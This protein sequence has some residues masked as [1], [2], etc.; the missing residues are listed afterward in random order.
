MKAPHAI[1]L[2]ERHQ[3]P[4]AAYGDVERDQS[5]EHLFYLED[6]A[7]AMAPLPTTYDVLAIQPYYFS[8]FGYTDL[9]SGLYLFPMG[10]EV[11][12]RV[13]E[14]AV[15]DCIRNDLS[16]IRVPDWKDKYVLYP[17]AEKYKRVI[18]LPGSNMLHVIDFNAVERLLH[19]DE[20]IMVKPHPIMT[21]EGL[22]ILGAKIGFNRIIDPRESGMDYLRNC[23]MAWGTANSEIGMRAALLGIAYRDITNTQFYPNM[24]YAPIH[25]LFS[26]DIERN[27]QVV[28]AALASKQS[29]FI[30]PWNTEEEAAERMEGFF[31]LAMKIR[32]QY[33]PMYPVH[34][35]MQFSPRQQKG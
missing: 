11:A 17:G 13:M 32:E 1:S 4:K 28:L 2:R 25:R 6:M 3:N 19:E 34:V 35:A 10:Y 20:S 8:E 24:T 15:G 30:M 33:K 12:A 27:K 26:E 29:G 16:G 23:E 9:W 22:R 21:L 5:L 18:F 7:D 31:G 14:Q